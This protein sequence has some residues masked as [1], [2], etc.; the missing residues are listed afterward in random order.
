MYNIVYNF[1]TNLNTQKN[2]GKQNCV[3]DLIKKYTKQLCSL[4][5][6]AAPLAA[7]TCRTIFYEPKEPEGLAQFADECKLL[8]K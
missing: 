6:L 7:R 5:L 4:A 3:V 2:G 1:T 8:R